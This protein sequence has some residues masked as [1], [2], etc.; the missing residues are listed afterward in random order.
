MTL[1]IL[2]FYKPANKN[3]EKP[4]GEKK[5]LTKKL[6]LLT[7]LCNWLNN[8]ETVGHNGYKAWKKYDIIEV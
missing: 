7:P 4:F 1:P 2:T 8:V 3:I 5:E 6:G